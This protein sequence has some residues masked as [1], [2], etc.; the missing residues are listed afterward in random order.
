MS[1]ANISPITLLLV[2]AGNMGRAMLTQWLQAGMQAENV[3]VIDPFAKREVLPEGVHLHTDIDEV[4]KGAGEES[5]NSYDIVVFAVKPQQMDAV[6]PHYQHVVST[7][8]V[9]ISIAAGVPIQKFTQLIGADIK[10]VRAMPNLPLLVGEGMTSLVASQNL[11]NDDRQRINALFDA[12]GE[13]I[14]LDD[15]EQMHLATALAGSAPAYFLRVVYGLANAGVKRGL[16][17]KKAQL[18][19][20]QTM[21]GTSAWLANETAPIPE[22]INRI[23]SKGGTTEAALCAFDATDVSLDDLMDAAVQQCVSRSKELSE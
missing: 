11:T 4:V 8:T 10:M 17:E 14:W 21:K 6:L 16:D 1:E 20:L 13:Y 9:V 18:L 15:E 12:L 19:A 2:G 22:L 7:N 23:T 5:H 3:T